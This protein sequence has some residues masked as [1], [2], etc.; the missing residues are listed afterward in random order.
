VVCGLLTAVAHA[1]PA[2]APEAVQRNSRG[3]ALMRDGKAAEAIEHFRAAVELSPGYATAQGNL[4][5]AYEQAGQTDE[6]MAAYQKVL[7]LDP[8]NTTVRNNLATLYSKAGRHDDAIR[9]YETLVA[10]DPGNDVARRNL[11]NA[12]RNKG[13][14]AERDERA[15]RAL[16]AA[17]ARPNDPRAAYEVARVYAQQ[18]D[19]DRALTWLSKAL[20]LGYDQHDYVKVDPALGE[21]R[22]DPRFATVVAERLDRAR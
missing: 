12:R 17:Q 8:A 11:E 13:I 18:G 1:Q 4:A 15:G 5:Y 16:A 14:L 20:D 7:D 6:A 19:N 9:E 21:L 2:P 3:A 22:K 10:R